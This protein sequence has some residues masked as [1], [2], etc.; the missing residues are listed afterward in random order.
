[1]YDEPDDQQDKLQADT[2]ESEDEA[3]SAV[4]LLPKSILMGQDASVGDELVLKITAI[5]D[6]QIRLLQRG[7]DG[8]HLATVRQVEETGL[9]VESLQRGILVVAVD[10]DMG[11]PFVLEELDEVD[12]KE[13]FADTAFAIEDEVES[14]HVFG[15]VTMRTWAIRGPRGRSGRVWSTSGSSLGGSEAPASVAVAGAAVTTVSTIGDEVDAVRLR[16]GRRRGRTISPSTS[17]QNAATAVLLMGRQCCV[18][19]SAIAR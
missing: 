16:P 7:E 4:G 10:G 11:D 14:F 13:A 18:S 17:W 3:A 9:R 12:G 15:V 2:P 5:H 1:M 8:V 19:S 6:D